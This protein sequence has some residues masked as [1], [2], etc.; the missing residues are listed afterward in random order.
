MCPKET[1]EQ[2]QQTENIRYNVM[3]AQKVSDYFSTYSD[4]GQQSFRHVSHNDT[5]EEDDSLQPAVTQ[6]D[7][8][9]EKRDAQE[10]GHTCNDM[11]EVLDLFGDGGLSGLQSRGQSSNAT[12]DCAVSGADDD[13]TCCA[14]FGKRTEI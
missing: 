13:A 12:H 14:C 10:D 11:D 9:D 8:Q 2:Q 6:D 7:G 3:K 5:D 4:S 1:N